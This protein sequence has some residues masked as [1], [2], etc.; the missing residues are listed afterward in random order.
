MTNKSNTNDEHSSSHGGYVKE[1]PDSDIDLFDLVLQLW[2]GK[3]VII[4]TVIISVLIGVVYINVVKE[5]WVS[6]ST[7]TLP[8]AGQVANYNA[9]LSIVYADSPQ[10]KPSLTG[11]QTQMFN[12][13]TASMSALAGALANLEKPL[14]LTLR[15]V[16]GSDDAVSISFVGQS[17]KEA[18]MQLTQYIS[19]VND[20]VVKDY[21]DDIKRNL[22]VKTRE[23]TNTLD[24]YKQVALNQKEHRLDVIKQALKIADASNVGKLQVNQAEFLSD[25]TLYLLGSD[26]LKAMVENENSKPLD[27]SKEY[28]DA[29]R[30]LLAVTHLKIEVDNLQSFRYISQP[31]LPLKRVSPK[32]GLALIL[33]FI[34]GALL[35][36]FIVIG[37]NSL[38]SYRNRGL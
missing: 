13:F 6:T 21:G 28:Y 24:T 1:Q 20:E 19:Q 3:V 29:Q 15:P 12:R 2:R 23:L 32:K 5:K 16:K 8:A 27:F 35:G 25:D 38:I 22:S 10:D 11:L 34:I 30:A 4:S 18:Q 9:A 31:D 26:A 33:A 17:A 36:S 37:R 14:T 7:V